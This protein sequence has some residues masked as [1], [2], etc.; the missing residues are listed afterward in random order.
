[1]A[2]E[3]GY[4]Q[5]NGTPELRQAIASM[6]PGASADH[7]EVTNGGSEANCIALW[8]L[9]EQGDDVVMM[10][11]NYMQVRGVARALGAASGRGALVGEGRTRWRS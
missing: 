10:M 3:L 6:Y 2:Q 8:H 11:P 1:M 4:T 9:V 5:T 7:I